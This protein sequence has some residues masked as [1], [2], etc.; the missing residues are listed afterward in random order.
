MLTRVRYILYFFVLTVF[1]T[2]FGCQQETS[3]IKADTVLL[4]G[5]IVTMS[6]DLS[7]AKA[8]AIKG[9][10]IISVGTNREVK[11]FIGEKTKVI[12]LEQKLV[13]PG[14]IDAHVHAFGVGRALTMT[15]LDLRGLTKRT[16]PG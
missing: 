15:A 2:I 13:I 3:A 7:R 10:S 4:N 12:D 8:M 16:D 14:F 5:N 1:F 9:N 6:D 11:P